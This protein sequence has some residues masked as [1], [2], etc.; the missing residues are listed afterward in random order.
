MTE[1]EMKKQLYAGPCVVT[2]TKADGSNRT[3][4]CSTNRA[5]LP[6]TEDM[7][8]SSGGKPAT[9]GIIKAFDIEKNGWRSFS[10][11]RV[12]SFTTE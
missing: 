9:P 3:M 10:V 7:E 12:I 11:D 2:F 4:R 1:E 8:K 6:I 5:F